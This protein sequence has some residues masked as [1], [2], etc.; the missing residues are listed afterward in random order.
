MILL[1]FSKILLRRIKIIIKMEENLSSNGSAG[2]RG[3]ER[4]YH[5][6]ER[7][8]LDKIFRPNNKDQFKMSITPNLKTRIS[9]EKFVRLKKREN[10]GILKE[11][12][13]LNR[14]II[15]ARPSLSI[16]KLTEDYNKSRK[17][18]RFSSKPMSVTKTPRCSSRQESGRPLLDVMNSYLFNVNNC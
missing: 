7:I 18:I 9:H 8:L 4:Q 10:Q 11:N 15:N 5:M 17:Y 3:L 1:L 12:M 14:S 6:A 2:H 16:K 13:R